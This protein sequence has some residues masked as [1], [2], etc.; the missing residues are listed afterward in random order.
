MNQARSQKIVMDGYGSY[1]GMEKGCFVIKDGHGNEER[2]PLFENPI[3]EVVLK[4]GNMVSTGALASLGFWDVDVMILTQRGRPVAMLKS[5]EDD[6]HVKTRLCQYEV[7]SNGKGFSIAKQLVRSKAEGQNIVLMK[8]GLGTYDLDYVQNR[9]DK[10]KPLNLDRIRS[11]LLQLESAFSKRYFN[12]IF[13][14]LPE[15]LRPEKRKTYGAYDGMNNIFNLAY[16]VL[17]WKVH[18]AVIR[19]KLEPYLG[20]LHSVQFGKPSLVCDM[21]ELYRYLVDDFV[22]KFCQDLEERDFTVK[23]EDVSRK[24]KGKREYLNNAETK[25]MMKELQEY[26]ESKVEIPLI[27]YGK[28]QKIETLIN[29]EALLFAKYLRHEVKTWNPRIAF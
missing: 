28:R 10:M 14:L 20:F 13:D 25:C 24:R 19:A 2:Y 29:E 3:G 17:S 18:R 7:L 26:F 1:L 15:G 11:R 23:S 27:R 16:E 5:L 6:S 12:L 22:I 21:Q 8:Y 4:S 9:L